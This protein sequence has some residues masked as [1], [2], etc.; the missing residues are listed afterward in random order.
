MGAVR[1]KAL[2]AD[3]LIEPKHEDHGLPLADTL[4]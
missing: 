3:G 1:E 2:E 4:K